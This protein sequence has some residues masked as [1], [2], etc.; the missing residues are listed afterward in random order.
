MTIQLKNKPEHLIQTYNFKYVINHVD[1]TQAEAEFVEK[2]GHLL[3]NNNLITRTLVDYEAK[4]ITIE[5]A[6]TKPFSPSKKV[7]NNR[8]FI[9]DLPT[10]N[11]L[12]DFIRVFEPLGITSDDFTLYNQ[13][14]KLVTTSN[15]L[16]KD[17]IN[18]VKEIIRLDNR[19]EEFTLIK[20]YDKRP[21][22]QNILDFQLEFLLE[23]KLHEDDITSMFI[24]TLENYNVIIIK[25]K[26]NSKY[27]TYSD[28]VEAIINSCIIVDRFESLLESALKE[29]NDN[30]IQRVISYQHPIVDSNSL[31]LLE[32]SV[33]ITQVLEDITNKDGDIEP[34]LEVI[35]SSIKDN[36]LTE[37]NI[38]DFATETLPEPEPKY[39]IIETGD[40]IYDKELSTLFEMHEVILNKS[41]VNEEDISEFITDIPDNVDELIAETKA[42]HELEIRKNRSYYPP[43]DLVFTEDEIQKLKDFLKSL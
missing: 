31:E 12:N 22:V 7:V 15:K 38:A 26:Q 39:P 5:G 16:T 4:T 13:E 19:E 23:N 29:G 34:K 28:D 9:F 6:S 18:N 33:N 43:K 3:D 8:G 41:K 27:K 14:H 11:G 21:T 10:A 2:Y 35:E 40:K 25:G 36:L 32:S 1:I 37:L 30:V 20:E 17:I 24:E 42:Y